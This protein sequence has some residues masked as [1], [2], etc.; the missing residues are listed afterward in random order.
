MAPRQ[1]NQYLILMKRHNTG[2]ELTIPKIV[3]DIVKSTKV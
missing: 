2:L 3:E 1:I